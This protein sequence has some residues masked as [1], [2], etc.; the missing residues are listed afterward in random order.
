MTMNP[1]AITRNVITQ[2]RSTLRCRK[3]CASETSSLCALRWP[4]SEGRK[5]TAESATSAPS[6]ATPKK[7]ARQPRCRASSRP[8]GTPSTEATEKA[9]ITTPMA[10]PRRCAGTTSAMM[11]NE[12]EVAGPP[13]APAST[14]A[15]MSECSP[16]AS[17]PNAVPTTRPSMATPRAG[18]RSNRPRK[19]DAA[20]PD[21]AAAA[22]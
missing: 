10:V 4:R 7:G 22:V 5:K 15:A 9:P 13:N 3:R 8:A 11:E 14:R 12:S 19:N 17:P 6:A 18:R 2:E 21:T 16:V 20:S 1:A